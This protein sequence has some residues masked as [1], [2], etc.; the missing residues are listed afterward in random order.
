V[1]RRDVEIIQKDGRFLVLLAREPQPVSLAQIAREGDFKL[2]HLCERIA[3][4]ERHLRRIFEEG[5]GIGP[6]EWLRHE[7]MV[8]ARVML[9]EGSQ[10]KEV[11]ANLGFSNQKIF[12][13]EF[14]IFHGVT[15]TTYKGK[16]REQVLKAVL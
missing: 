3:L 11:A 6:K 4:S 5:I 9:R 15:P 8:A 1:K 10:I 12:S 16:H 14:Q 13:R 7:R 2:S